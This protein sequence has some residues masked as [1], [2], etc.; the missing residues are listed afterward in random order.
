[1]RTG[2]SGD[3]GSAPAGSGA[4]RSRPEGRSHDSRCSHKSRG[5]R[6]SGGTQRRLVQAL[7]HSSAL[8]AG[9]WSWPGHCYFITTNC[10]DKQALLADDRCAQAVVDSLG[11]LQRQ[12]RIR[13]MGFVVMPDHVHLA[14]VL[15]GDEES[16]SGGR[17]HT[18]SVSSGIVGA[19][20]RARPTLAAVMN[21]FKGFTGKR[22]NEILQ[23]RGEVWQPAYH[24]HRVRDREDFVA[25]LSYMHGNPVR[26]GLVRFEHEFAFSSANPRYAGWVDWAWLDG[27]EA[28]RARKGA[29]TTAETDKIW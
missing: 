20:F 9:R 11:W 29:P 10:A 26:K 24:D 1:M 28:G 14:F 21:S 6:N 16:R 8:R 15:G 25:R 17:S 7:P 12:E 5:A 27:I 2:R 22:I 19:P 13:L 18:G 23:R 3:V 4:G